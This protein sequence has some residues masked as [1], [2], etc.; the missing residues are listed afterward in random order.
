MLVQNSCRCL[1]KRR[2]KDRLQGGVIILGF[3]FRQ[4]SLNRKKARPV[5][6]L[7]K[8]S[9]FLPVLWAMLKRCRGKA[10]PN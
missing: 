1:R 8:L 7:L 4:I 9:T 2:E 6:L 10:R 5:T 3:R